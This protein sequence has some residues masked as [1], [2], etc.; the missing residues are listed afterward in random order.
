MARYQARVVRSSNVAL[1]ARE[2][3][4]FL[5]CL[6]LFGVDLVGVV[7]V[8]DVVGVLRRPC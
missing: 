6:G 2:V 8:V 1:V 5:R 3:F 4:A 7:V